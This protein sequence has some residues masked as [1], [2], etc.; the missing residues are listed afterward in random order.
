MQLAREPA[1]L[2]LLGREHP[3]DGVA[4]HPL[5][6]VDCDRGARRERLRESQVVVGERGAMLEPVVRDQHADPAPAHDK[7]HIQARVDA[8]AASRPLVDLRVD[9]SDSAPIGQLRALWSGYQPQMEAYRLRAIDP[10]TAPTYGV[11]GDP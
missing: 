3:A 6:E 10:T 9:W 5:G 8:E 1:P 4:A 11:A 7:G 2:E